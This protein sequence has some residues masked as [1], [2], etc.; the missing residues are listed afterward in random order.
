MGKNENVG[1]HFWIINRSNNGDY[2]SGQVL[3]TAN[4]GKRDFKSEQL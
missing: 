1:K 4:R 2:K 3:G